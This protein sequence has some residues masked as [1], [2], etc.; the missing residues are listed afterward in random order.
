MYRNLPPRATEDELTRLVRSLQ[1]WD[2]DEKTRQRLISLIRSL[3]WDNNKKVS[4]PSQIMDGLKNILT[5]TEIRLKDF[6]ISKLTNDYDIIDIRNI[7]LE[8]ILS[9]NP[10]EENYDIDLIEQEIILMTY[11]LQIKEF[12][13]DYSARI[14]TINE[15][16]SPIKGKKMFINT[17]LNLLPPFK[18]VI[19]EEGRPCLNFERGSSEQNIKTSINAFRYLK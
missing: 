6:L 7:I 15:Y 13:Q 5:Q 16:I 3:K 9:Y 14:N 12:P 19:D 18:I 11:F 2:V 4:N 17:W 8:M 1:S 10:N